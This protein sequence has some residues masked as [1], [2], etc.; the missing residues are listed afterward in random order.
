MK[1]III[2]AEKQ[3]IPQFNDDTQQDE[4]TLV[5]VTTVQF[6]NDDGTSHLTQTYAQ[7]PSEIDADNPSAYF[8][9][10]AEILQT[11]V[12][13]QQ[14]NQQQ[15]AQSTLADEIIEKLTV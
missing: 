15:E 4:P 13:G 8:D 1:A 7:K 9:R 3:T 6:Q 11:D 5:V 12:D 2:S 10:Q 14:A